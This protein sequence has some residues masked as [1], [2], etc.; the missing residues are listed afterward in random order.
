MSSMVQHP[1]WYYITGSLGVGLILGVALVLV[2]LWICRRSRKSKDVY[3]D[4]P[5][6]SGL[7]LDMTPEYLDI[8]EQPSQYE[9]TDFTTPYEIADLTCPMYMMNEGRLDT[10]ETN[11]PRCSNQ[12]T[13]MPGYTD[14]DYRARVDSHP[15]QGLQQ[16]QVHANRL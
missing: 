8:I 10:E 11:G 13:L 9:E 3:K 15:Y 4:A 12:N 1:D 16:C 2:I 14:L 5:S 7:E 6:S